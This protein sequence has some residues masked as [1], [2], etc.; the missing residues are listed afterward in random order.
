MGEVAYVSEVRVEREGG[1]VRRA[2]LPVE[3]DP[4]WYGAHGPVREHYGY[5]EGEFD[6]HATTLDHVV[7]AA[8]G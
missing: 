4:V 1:P 5:P 7:A 3:N 8:A 6:D 2:Y